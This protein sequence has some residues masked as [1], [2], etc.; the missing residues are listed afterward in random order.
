MNDTSEPN[1]PGRRPKYATEEERAAAR[2]E[3]TNRANREKTIVSINKDIRDQLDVLCDQL[4]AEFSFRP[5]LAQALRY[6]IKK[7]KPGETGHI[8]QGREAQFQN[9]LLKKKSDD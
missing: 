5:T 2:R 1:K 4:E 3:S 9:S 8:E 6:L 7:G